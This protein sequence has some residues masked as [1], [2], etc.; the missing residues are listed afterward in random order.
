MRLVSGTNCVETWK[1]KKMCH[2]ISTH[3]ACICFCQAL[4]I[5]LIKIL[6]ND[7]CAKWKSK[8]TPLSWYAMYVYECITQSFWIINDFR[9]FTWYR[10]CFIHQI[11]V[12]CTFCYWKI[13]RRIDLGNFFPKKCLGF[14]DEFKLTMENKPI[15]WHKWK[16]CDVTRL[17]SIRK[18]YFWFWQIIFFKFLW[19]QALLIWARL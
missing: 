9:T 15:V 18:K 17:L 13:F 1:T 7:S 19:R 8:D 2:L 14:W 5:N 11:L 12:L 4:T 6:T 16:V 10:M 3:P